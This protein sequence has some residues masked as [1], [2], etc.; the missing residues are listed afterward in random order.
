MLQSLWHQFTAYWQ[1]GR[2]CSPYWIAYWT[3]HPHLDE[4][5]AV[6]HQSG[7]LQP[8]ASQTDQCCAFPTESKATKDFGPVSI[9]QGKS[10]CV[11]GSTSADWAAK[12]PRF[13]QLSE[14]TLTK[15]KFT[16][17]GGFSP[18][19]SSLRRRKAKQQLPCLPPQQGYDTHQCWLPTPSTDRIVLWHAWLWW[20]D[21]FHLLVSLN[22]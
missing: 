10:L 12:F 20:Q 2:N 18:I 13:P 17:L 1:H 14:E 16:L 8:S 15:A 5:F 19:A 6:S 7:A 22:V 9:F 4:P 3:F 11:K 21:S